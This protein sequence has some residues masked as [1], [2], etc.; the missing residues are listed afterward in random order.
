MFFLNSLAVVRFHPLPSPEQDS[1]VY[2]GIRR[3][4]GLGDSRLRTFL[5]LLVSSWGHTVRRPS[6]VRK[7]KKKKR[8]K[9]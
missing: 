3:T 5:K 6:S 7:K 8:K 9:R 1:P 4:K 2:E